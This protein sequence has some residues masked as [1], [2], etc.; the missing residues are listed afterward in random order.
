VEQEV[1]TGV[2]H[3]NV[4]TPAELEEDVLSFYETCLGLERIKKPIGTR[5]S[6]AWFR[7]GS[8]E[9]HVS[10]D[11]HNPQ[12]D[13]H[14]GLVVSNFDA[15]VEHIRD[16]GCHIEQAHPIPGRERC[17]IRDPAGNLVELIAYEATARVL[18][19]EPAAE[20]GA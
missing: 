8:A 9:I 11:E 6:G 16:A 5:P 2:D 12:R 15:T 18:Y 17:F 7:A 20:G 19:E 14:F 10:I 13:S 4:T 3:V 1:V